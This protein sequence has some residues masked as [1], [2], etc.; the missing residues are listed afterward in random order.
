MTTELSL[1]TG[2]GGG[3]WA[4]KMLG[5]RVVGYVEWDKNAQQ[6]IQAR[7]QD[8]SFDDAPIFSDI[9]TFISDGY[10]DAYCGHVDVVS[11]GFPCQPFSV[12]G[13]QRLES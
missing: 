12:A 7:I 11:G 1:F 9:R 8:G 10:A 2:G 4:A 6:V 13:R 5:H 3:V